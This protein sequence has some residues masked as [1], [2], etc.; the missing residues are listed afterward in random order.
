MFPYHPRACKSHDRFD[1]LA[2]IT[3]IAMN[4]AVGASWLFCA[5][6]TVLEPQT[7][8][9]FQLPAVIAECP[10]MLFAAVN[11]QHRGNG[12]PFSRKAPIE[13]RRPTSLRNGSWG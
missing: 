13:A 7:N 5:K 12:F 3:L 11:A 6:S 1:L 8:I 4:R 10:V 9:P 2:A